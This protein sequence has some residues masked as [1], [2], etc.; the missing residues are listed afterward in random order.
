MIPDPDYSDDD[1]ES[2][3]ASKLAA[4]NNTINNNK[5]CNNS[6]FS[7]SN[8]SR[9]LSS[10]SPPATLPP[11]AAPLPSSPVSSPAPLTSSAAV[12][13]NMVLRNNR[14]NAAGDESNAPLPPKPGSPHPPQKENKNGRFDENG[15]VLPKKLMNPSLD[16]T[17]K[18]SLHRELLFNQKIGVSVLNQ[19]TEL[20]KAMEKHKG[21][22]IAKE[23]QKEK[24]ANLSPFQKALEQQA[25]KLEQV[26]TEKTD[27]TKKGSEAELEF[28][29]LQAKLRSKLEAQ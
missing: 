9:S 13:A 22:Q 20:Q 1:L 15:L 16:S 23:Q 29:K 24:Q 19:K 14:V 27:E 18:K 4:I 10:S 12:P 8:K 6:I 7:S 26:G 17:E 25:L 5:N 2:L 11:T 21:K 3:A 28:Q